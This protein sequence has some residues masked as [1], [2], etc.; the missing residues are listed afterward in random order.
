MFQWGEP[1]YLIVNSQTGKGEKYMKSILERRSIRKYTNQAV[2][3]ETIK[4]LLEAAMS[5]PSAGNEQP[6]HFIVINDHKLLEEIPKFHPYSQM[7]KEAPVAILVCGDTRLEKY[8][9]FWVQ[10]CSA[11]TE[12]IL[13]AV[14][15]EGLGAVWLG[16][17]PMQDRVDGI[18]NLFRLPEE[19][20]PLA[21]IPIGYP[22]EEK[23]ATHRFD[24]ER[25]HYNLW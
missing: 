24:Q 1:Y 18:K 7:L 17:Y 6:W 19:V 13:I 3:E 15:E 5:A 10:D 9:G 8:P 16:L 14:A 4:E 12:N 20:I 23:G 21:L 11:A 25:I 2:S 22:A